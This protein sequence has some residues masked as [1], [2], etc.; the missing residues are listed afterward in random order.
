MS[1][2]WARGRITWGLT[3]I[4]T[5]IISNVNTP[6]P[7]GPDVH[8]EY[9][10]LFFFLFP[11]NEI[12]TGFVIPVRTQKRYPLL[13]RLGKKMDRFNSLDKRLHVTLNDT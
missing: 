10:F 9:R 11:G 1:A 8:N 4:S 6:D 5:R 3:P 2:C 13:T 7:F 12:V